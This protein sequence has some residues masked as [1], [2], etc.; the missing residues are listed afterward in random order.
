MEKKCD[1]KYCRYPAR[2]GGKKCSRCHRAGLKEKNP[3]YVAWQTTKSN[4][5]RRGKRFVITLEEFREFCEETGYLELK[6][7]DAD[8]ASI[9]CII[10]EIGYAKG[11]IECLAL[12]DNTL[13][14]HKKVIYDWVH[15]EYILVERS[16]AVDPD[17]DLPF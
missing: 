1:T 4:A 14:R 7:K 11:N 10:D 17:D 8:S 2:K 6:G 15:R 13:K 9:D 5:K 16:I 3:V 12:R